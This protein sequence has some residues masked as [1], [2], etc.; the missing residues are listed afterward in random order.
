MSRE[1]MNLHALKG[2]SWYQLIPGMVHLIDEANF[3]YDAQDV[4]P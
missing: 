3:G 2:N 1:T 4:T